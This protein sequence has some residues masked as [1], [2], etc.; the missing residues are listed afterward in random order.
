VSGLSTV[1]QAVNWGGQR[2][3]EAGL[4]DSRLEARILLEFC[5][6]LTP[7]MLRVAAYRRLDPEEGEAYREMVEARANREPLAY[8]TGHQ[9]FYGLDLVVDER[10]LVPRQETELLV[11]QAQ[12]VLRE[13]RLASER[14]GAKA[15]LSAPSGLGTPAG[16][17][18]QSDGPCV[19]DVGTG[20]GAVAVAIATQ[21]P[22]AFVYALDASADALSVAADNVRRYKVEERT[23]LL[24]GDLLDPLPEPADLIL[25]NLPYV[26]TADLASAQ[27]EVQREPR[28][29]LDGGP[30]GLDAYR[31]FLGQAPAHLKAGGA[32]LFEIGA[33][34]GPAALDLARQAFPGAEALLMKD[35]AGLD[36]LV[37]LKTSGG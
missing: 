30:D 29:A 36:R 7:E 33:D 37:L 12:K 9:A 11:E 28:L 16:T 19:V 31:R 15:T 18:L 22:D 4:E 1:V 23:A 5:L 26:T 25:A 35:L 14:A 3:A 6:G 32:L 20:S 10:T 27:P 17:G 24:R 2:L 34:Q 8:V 13:R 21:V